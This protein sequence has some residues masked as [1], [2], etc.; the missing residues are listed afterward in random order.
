MT[1]YS[2]ANPFVGPRAI[3]SGE[4]LFGRTT[5]LHALASLIAANRIVLL[6]APS[7]AGKSSLIEA[8]LVPRMH[9]SGFQVLPTV[10]IGSALPAGAPEGANR[11]VTSL[12]MGLGARPEDSLADCLQAAT[13][14]ADAEDRDTLLVIDQFE[15]I[16]TRAPHDRET[17]RA[18]LKQIAAALQDPRLFA[19]FVIREDYLAALAPDARI[20]PTR[21]KATFRLGLLGVES[22]KGAAEKLTEHSG[23]RFDEDAATKLM[24]KLSGSAGGV[25]EPVQFQVVCRRLW[26]RLRPYGGTI[27]AD[28]VERHANIKTALAEYYDDAVATAARTSGVAERRIRN[29]IEPAL[30]AGGGVRGQ[31]LKGANNGIDASV[32]DA[33]RDAHIVRA[34]ERRGAVWYELAHDS[35]VSPI[36]HSNRDW[37]AKNTTILQQHAR[38]WADRSRPRELL[39]SPRQLA[40]EEEDLD[41]SSLDPDELA[42]LAECRR[43]R[44]LRRTYLGLGLIGLAIVVLTALTIWRLW[45]DAEASAQEA[46]RSAEHAKQ[47]GIRNC[48][49]NFEPHIAALCLVDLAQCT[50]ESK[51]ESSGRCG[52]TTERSARKLQERSWELATTP[53]PYQVFTGPTDNV[54]DVEFDPSGRRLVYASSDGGVRVQSAD[55]GEAIELRHDG[56]VVSRVRFW[57]GDANSWS[58]VAVDH[59]GRFIVWD[60][61]GSKRVIAARESDRYFDLAVHR[62]TGL[63]VAGSNKGR[64]DIV[65]LESGEITELVEADT[66]KAVFAVDISPDG[67]WAAS[68][69]KDQIPRVWSVADPRQSFEFTPHAR[70]I[71]D[72]RFSSDSSR[73]VTASTDKTARITS[74]EDSGIWAQFAVENELD[75]HWIRSAALSP[76]GTVLLTASRNGRADLWRVPCPLQPIDSRVAE[77]ADTGPTPGAAARETVPQPAGV[78][79]VGSSP[80]SSTQTDGP[81]SEDAEP[82]SYLEGKHLASLPHEGDLFHAAWSP[83]GDR[84]AT[85]S[86][87]GTV[88]IGSKVGH[89]LSTFKA[90]RLAVET[91]AFDPTGTLLA[92]GSRDRSASV[93]LTSWPGDGVAPYHAKD[94]A[95]AFDSDGYLVAADSEGMV[96]RWIPDTG[97]VVSEHACCPTLHRYRVNK[98]Y[99][100][101]SATHVALTFKDDADICLCDVR[102]SSRTRQ[103][104]FGEL[105]ELLPGCAE[106]SRANPTVRD[107]VFSSGDDIA[108]AYADGYARVWRHSE[109]D[110]PPKFVLSHAR[111][112]VDT[113]ES[114]NWVYAASFLNDG[115]RLATGARDGVGRIWTLDETPAAQELAVPAENHPPRILAVATSPDQSVV[116]LAHSSGRARIWP[117]SADEE[118]SPVATLRAHRTT[119]PIREVVFSPDGRYLVTASDDRSARV[120]LRPSS[121]WDV[122]EPEAGRVQDSHLDRIR[123]ARFSQDGSRILTASKDGVTLEWSPSHQSEEDLDVVL[124]RK[125]GAV[126]GLGFQRGAEARWAFTLDSDGQTRAWLLDWAELANQHQ[127]RTALCLTAKQRTSL[128]GEST[129]VA[130]QIAGECA[131]RNQSHW[132]PS[133]SAQWCTTTAE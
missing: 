73:I 11:F 59:A 123:L 41:E 48:A 43:Q 15:E 16:I 111:R 93:W 127:C 37:I 64:V 5:E 50:L 108:V 42:F 62:D 71:L 55:G 8:A 40:R 26:A 19:L 49:L 102:D 109:G 105:P 36:Q 121:G 25:V 23:L 14:R 81:A 84:F 76:D 92:T 114:C 124:R 78:Q 115:K 125:G 113:R 9:D 118:V 67:R 27:T 2:D 99:F 47:L 60:S 46:R 107:I 21:W 4:Q 89:S 72:I 34:E 22:A 86:T 29:W 69:G 130:A 85:T 122:R 94:I 51:D 65:D 74:M 77:C 120:W 87:L 90:H 53:F 3:R 131:A 1:E 129:A 44:R 24:M 63:A 119:L 20:I 7:G 95:A 98:A 110:S 80:D 12:L 104:Q 100:D 97:A 31:I 132:R 10:R 83:K 66:N 38:E 61:D 17:R 39:L 96:R 75:R 112:S 32:I 82:P 30:I 116:V 45:T 35:L 133:T 126:A 18:A 28:D 128:F 117:A 106:R 70:T 6:H 88:Q 57:K 33:L 52:E 103:L 54:N 56:A 13:E 68:G 101:D 91:A 79:T 58:V